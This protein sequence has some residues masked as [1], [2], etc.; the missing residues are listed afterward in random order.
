MPFAVADGA[1]GRTWTIALSNRTGMVE[2]S[3]DRC[4]ELA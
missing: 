3:V 2:Q 1:L 4:S